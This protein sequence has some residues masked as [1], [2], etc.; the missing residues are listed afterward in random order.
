MATLKIHFY[1]N[2]EEY[3]KTTLKPIEKKKKDVAPKS[4]VKKTEVVAST[5]KVVSK[6]ACTSFK[7]EEVEDTKKRKH[8]IP[9]GYGVDEHDLRLLKKMVKVVSPKL[10]NDFAELTNSDSE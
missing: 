6:R 7:T 4:A 10:A 9:Q 8:R 2:H 3:I 1:Q 5:S